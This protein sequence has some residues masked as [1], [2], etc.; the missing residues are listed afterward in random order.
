MTARQIVLKAT[1]P[2]WMFLNRVLG[3]RLKV[4]VNKGNIQ[5]HQS[6]YNLSAQLNNG[7]LLSFENFKGKKLLLVNTASDCGYTSQYADLQ[8]L[9]EEYHDKLDVLA[10]PAN[11][12]G[13]QEKGN[14][15]QIKNFC[16]KNFHI[17]FPVALKASVVKGQ[18]QQKVFQWL[19]DETKNGWNNKAPSWNF[20][21]YLVNEEGMLTNYF[22][23][24][25]SPLSDEVKKALEQ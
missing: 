9:Y 3:K 1:Y 4:L 18:N 12:F 2:V 25:I 16:V 24:A 19:T 20:S 13:R 14:D 15:E 17:T 5:P 11:D 23:P 21:K 8:K 7:T 10:F 22:D 6:F